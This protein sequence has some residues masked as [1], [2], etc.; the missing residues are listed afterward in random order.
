[1]NKEILS[2][3]GYRCDLC[4][5]Y[6]P[7]I[8]EKDERKKLS[9]GWHNY[10]GFRIEQENILCDGCTYDDNPELI[11]KNCPVRPCVLA[12]ALENCA[13]CEEYVCEKLKERIVDYDEIRTK[14]GEEIPVEDYENFIKPYESKK[15]LD[16][17]RENPLK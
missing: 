8:V 15:R 12:K 11:D 2:K 3:C 13:Y 10:F 4:L 14:H 6:R 17:I 5:A 16:L 1:M 9:D 7:N